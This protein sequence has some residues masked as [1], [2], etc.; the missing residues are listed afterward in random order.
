DV[1]GTLYYSGDGVFGELRTVDKSTGLTT[2]VATLTGA[3][4][5]T[6]GIAAMSAHSDTGVLFAVALNDSDVIHPAYL[7]TIN[8]STGEVT[9]IGELLNDFDAIA[10]D[11][12]PVVVGY[13]DLGPSSAAV[14]SDPFHAGSHVLLVRG[15]S[16]NDTIVVDSVD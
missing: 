14:V 6:D 8:T 3:P 7:V 13:P 11:T 9:I 10:F 4:G 12:P 15:T 1:N 2:V 5:N 16:G